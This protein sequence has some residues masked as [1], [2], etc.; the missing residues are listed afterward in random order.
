MFLRGHFKNCILALVSFFALTYIYSFLRTVI[1]SNGERS[2]KIF[3][4]NFCKLFRFKSSW[5]IIN[6]LK[7]QHELPAVL[8]K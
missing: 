4:T 5:E 6:D 8:K 3:Q 1:L 2:L 7:C